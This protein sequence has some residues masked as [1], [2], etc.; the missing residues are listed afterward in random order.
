M[1]AVGYERHGPLR[2]TAAFEP[3]PRYQQAGVF[4]LR[5]G[6]RCET[7]ARQTRDFAEH[8]LEFVQEFQRALHGCIRL[9]RVD[10][11]EPGQ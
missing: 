4:A 11:A 9:G 6:E 8:L 2:L 7:D 3:R 10:L 5:T 1:R